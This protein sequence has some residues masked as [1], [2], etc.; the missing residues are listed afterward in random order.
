MPF[1]SF[2]FINAMKNLRTKT[3]VTFFLSVITG[4]LLPCIANAQNPGLQSCTITATG[5]GKT[6]GDIVAMAIYNPTDKEVNG[7]LGPYY[8]PSGGNYQPYITMKSNP[9]T[10]PA[11]KTINITL[12][13]FCADITKP[14]ATEKDIF[15]PISTW[16]KID[17]THTGVLPPVNINPDTHP[18]LAAPYYLQALEAI[19]N[20]YDGMKEKGNITTPFS[21][22]PEKERESVI[23]QTFWIYTS[24]TR[25]K[26][27]TK[28]QFTE[29]TYAQYENS[30]HIN[31][32][33]LST[34][35]KQQLDKGI[36]DFWNTFQAVGTEAKVLNTSTTAP[37]TLYDVRVTR[38]EVPRDDIDIWQDG[39]K[40]KP[41]ED[42]K[43]E[44]YFS[45]NRIYIFLSGLRVAEFN[46]AN[47]GS[48]SIEDIINR[49]SDEEYPY[50]NIGCDSLEKMCNKTAAYN[51]FW[52][53]IYSVVDQK[54]EKKTVAGVTREKGETKSVLITRGWTIDCCTGERTFNLFFQ[55]MHGGNNANFSRKLNSIKI[56][57][58]NCPE[59][60]KKCDEM[61]K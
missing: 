50:P 26:P 25:Q 30:S 19:T 57:P 55:G 3:R 22:N 20:T 1:F 41:K 37:A 35:K 14:A 27:Y 29:R 52:G 10:V 42:D 32:S 23:Q 59:C 6:T 11:G 49:F 33:N 21:G 9:V 16:I 60:Q 31:P 4:L 46:V 15:K 17:D 54:M 34:D 12:T 28:E 51:L 39:K 18:E 38:T 48:E 43:V 47:D 5:T 61:K 56:C 53:E 24:A 7:S 58:I 13:G 2:K 40:V 36:D 45:G 8:I 44:V